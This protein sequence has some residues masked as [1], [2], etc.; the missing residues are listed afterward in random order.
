MTEGARATFHCLVRF[1]DLTEIRHV[2]LAFLAVVFA[3]VA[4]ASV[5]GLTFFPATLANYKAR[6]VLLPLPL[7]PLFLMPLKGCDLTALICG[8]R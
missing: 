1:H 8:V 5:V 6:A 7:L 3:F 4:S 2:V